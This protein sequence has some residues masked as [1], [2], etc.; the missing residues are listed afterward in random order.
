MNNKSVAL[1]DTLANNAFYDKYKAK[2]AA[3]QQYT[4]LVF[5]YSLYLFTFLPCDL[6]NVTRSDPQKLAEKLEQL[7]GA[8]KTVPTQP[9][10]ELPS[11][12]AALPKNPLKRSD[13]RGEYTQSPVKKLDAIMKTELLADKSDEEIKLVSVI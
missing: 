8:K 9:Q 11:A 3:L 1:D 12:P 7:T 13:S 6:L 10:T 5:T 2:I 4:F